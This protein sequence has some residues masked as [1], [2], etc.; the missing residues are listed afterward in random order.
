M[1]L[2]RESSCDF[3]LK[4]NCSQSENNPEM[5]A[6]RTQKVLVKIPDRRAQG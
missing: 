6:S 5:N 4:K 3:I 2:A 1:I